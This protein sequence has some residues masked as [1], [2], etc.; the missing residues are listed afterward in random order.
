M[1]K[2]IRLRRAISKRQSLVEQKEPRGLREP[3]V[4]AL[5]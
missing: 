3:R 1:N 4:W 2:N 5:F